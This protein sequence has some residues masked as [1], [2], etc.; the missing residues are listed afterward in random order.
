MTKG[1]L[2]AVLIHC[3]GVTFAMT[4]VLSLVKVLTGTI[5][6]PILTGATVFYLATVAWVSMRALR[7]EDAQTNAAAEFID[8]NIK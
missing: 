1:Q 7:G 2:M 6:E 3:A 8:R 5:S 4:I